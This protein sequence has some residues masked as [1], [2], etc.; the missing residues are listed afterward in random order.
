MKPTRLRKYEEALMAYLGRAAAKTSPFSTLTLVGL[1][2]WRSSGSKSLHLSS[3]QFQ[4]RTVDLR[5]HRTLIQRLLRNTAFQRPLPDHCL[6]QRNPTLWN[7]GDNL[8][9]YY[10]VSTQEAAPSRSQEQ[11]VSI[12]RTTATERI[13]DL[14]RSAEHRTVGQLVSHLTESSSTNRA[15]VRAYVDR[16]IEQQVLEIALPVYEHDTAYDDEICKWLR[17]DLRPEIEQIGTGMS[18]VLEALQNFR[19]GDTRERISAKRRIDTLWDGLE[20]FA[21]ISRTSVSRFYEDVAINGS[22]L[23]L[24]RR[25]LEPIEGD[26]ALLA[27][28]SSL[29]QDAQLTRARIVDLLC[30]RGPAAELHLLELF[31]ILENQSKD[32]QKSGRSV[33]ALQELRAQIRKAMRAKIEVQ[34]DGSLRLDTA[35]VVRDWRG[36][37][38]WIELPEKM[39]FFV[40]KAADQRE[41]WVVN[42]P[43]QGHGRFFSRFVHIMSAGI[44][45]ANER[46]AKTSEDDVSELVD[47][48]VVNAANSNLHVPLTRRAL[49]YPGHSH[50]SAWATIAIGN[51][52]VYLDSRRIPRLRCTKTGRNIRPMHFGFVTPSLLSGLARLLGAF[53]PIGPMPLPW[54]VDFVPDAAARRHIPRIYWG[55]V[56]LYRQ[57]WNLFPRDLAEIGDDR[58]ESRALCKLAAL[59][60]QHG[61]PS[62]VFATVDQIG[63]YTEGG[64]IDQEMQADKNHEMPK[65][66]SDRGRKPQY[67]NLTSPLWLFRLQRLAR[68]THTCLSLEEVYPHPNDSLMN[69]PR[70]RHAIELV[71]ELS[72]R[73]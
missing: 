24:D 45:L 4:N 65:Q 30:A 29:F 13:L 55:D 69:G 68:H 32:A 58:D 21:N 40:Q 17:R 11:L 53:G 3:K 8:F 46:S 12:P 19:N 15:K 64:R 70:G 26:L 2:H 18:E 39:G 34:R 22:N 60:H 63:T 38:E 9:R 57:R 73:A 44:P 6:I 67:L 54:L 72:G 59:A 43:Q 52:M 62:E 41:P 31:A 51:L 16:L 28:V 5:L 10:R 61:L 71:I 14:L 56:M 66:R 49:Q 20:D 42:Y 47:I 48:G 7:E 25:L 50:D 33:S 23:V 36:A 35:S 37:H 27:E 1:G